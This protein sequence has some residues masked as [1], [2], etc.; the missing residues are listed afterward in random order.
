[1]RE[2]IELPAH[3]GDVAAVAARYGADAA[4]GAW[5]DF[6]A[7]MNPA[8][9]P[10]A[11]IAALRAGAEDIAT[12]MRYPTACDR[13]LRDALAS[14]NARAAEEIVPA[15]GAAALIEAFVRVVA[16]RRCVVPQPAFS[17]YARALAAARCATIAPRL[18]PAASFTLDAHALIALFRD[19]RPDACILTNPHN[20]SGALTSAATMSAIVEEAHACG[21]ALLIDEAFIDY[22]PQASV[23]DAVRTGDVLVVR[24]LTKFYAMPALRVGYGIAPPAFARALIAHIPSWPITSLA[25][26]A[27][28]AAL[29]DETYARE[30][31]ATNARVRERF[32][33]D[34]RALGLTVFPSAANFVLAEAP[35]PSG[36]LTEALARN[37]RLI[38]RD[39]ATYETLEHGGFVRIA[40]RTQEENDRL[41]A[42][43]AREL[44]QLAATVSR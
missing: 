25:A 6:S 31:R 38:V 29:P 44:P 18:D 17:E 7:N 14:A 12:L 8:G 19:E 33:A 35:V 36:T 24:S 23:V 1:V 16:P 11:V 30:T 4:H 42:A 5:I 22:V 21:V 41:V 9:P 34:L 13:A 15:N 10:A 20:P 40:V 3:G 43:L 27:A 32:T 2:P 28:R 37:H 39:C 26:D